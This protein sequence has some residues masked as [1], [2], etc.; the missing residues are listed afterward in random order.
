MNNLDFLLG[1]EKLEINQSLDELDKI[2]KPL[3]TSRSNRKKRM[4][5]SVP[6]TFYRDLKELADNTG[7]RET[8]I[9][10]RCAEYGYSQLY[11]G[12]KI[13]H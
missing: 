4:S 8:Q 2:V 11:Q 6:E 5:L 1:V 9:L 13:S 12:V 7:E 3:P 10:L